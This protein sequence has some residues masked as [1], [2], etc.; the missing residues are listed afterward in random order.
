MGREFRFGA[1][2][3]LLLAHSYASLVSDVGVS[4]FRISDDSFERNEFLD[5]YYP[6]NETRQPLQS[7]PLPVAIFF[8][9]FVPMTYLV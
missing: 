8:S 3:V 9:G 1:F 7:L 5:V 2:M 4:K 6:F